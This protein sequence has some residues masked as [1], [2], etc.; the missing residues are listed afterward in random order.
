MTLVAETTMTGRRGLLGQLWRYGATGLANTALGYGLIMV[1]V[2][3]LGASIIV[4]NCVGYGAGWCLSYALNKRWTFRHQ[5]AVARSALGFAALAAGCFVAN[6]AVTLS[7]SE[8]GLSFPIAQ[9]IGTA[10]YSIAFFAG[11]KWMV[12][13]HD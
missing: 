5:G 1:C 4:A 6:L 8:L 2:Y 11:L 7:L 3:G 12:F 13:K 10:T 9:I